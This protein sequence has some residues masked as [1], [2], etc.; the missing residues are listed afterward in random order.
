MKINERDQTTDPKSSE[1]GQKAKQ[2]TKTKPCINYIEASTNQRLRENL[3][4]RQKSDI[5][6]RIKG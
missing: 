4:D 5:V 3:E 6:Y 2:K 1:K